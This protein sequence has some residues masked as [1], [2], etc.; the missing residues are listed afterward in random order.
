MR[1]AFSYTRFSSAKSEG[2]DSLARQTREAEAYA[3]RIG[4]RLDKSLNMHDA[5][6]SASKD[7]KG[8][9]LTK[10]AL[11]KFVAAVKAKMIPPNSILIVEAI[12]R[13]TR[14][15]PLEATDLMKIILEAG[16]EIHTIDGDEPKIYTWASVDD[17]D[18]SDLSNQ[19]DVAR[20]FAKKLGRRLAH[21]WSAKKEEMAPGKVLSHWCPAWMRVVDSQL[22]NG[23]RVGGRYELIKDRVLI[24]QEIFRRYADGEGMQTIAAS[25]NARGEPLFTAAEQG[26]AVKKRNNG[27]GWRAVTILALL[28]NVAVLG[29]W[30][31]DPKIDRKAGKV[32]P[33]SIREPV[34]GVYEAIIDQATW[35]RCQAERLR[36]RATGGPKNR[37]LRNL[38]GSLALCEECVGTMGLIGK[39]YHVHGNMV[40]PADAVER[41][42][43]FVCDNARRLRTCSN[44]TSYRAL[45]IE[46][47]VLNG[48]RNLA[49][50]PQRPDDEDTAEIE[51]DI[52][53]ARAELV[54]REMTLD[55]L[56]ELKN[57][58]ASVLSRV[59]KLG[60]EIEA[61]K[62]DI[63]RLEAKRKAL[64]QR[65]Q[66]AEMVNIID[67]LRAE[68]EVAEGDA[69]VTARA[70]LGAYLGSILDFVLFSADGGVL[71]SAGSGILTFFVES[72]APTSVA[73]H[74]GGRMW[75]MPAEGKLGDPVADVPEWVALMRALGGKG[76]AGAV[77]KGLRNYIDASKQPAQARLQK[78]NGTRAKKA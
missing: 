39:G 31:P 35:D 70:A 74:A 73:F 67:K 43:Y 17:G 49:F 14:G 9:H 52:D 53:A 11:G 57:M 42:N 54:G 8:E 4:A 6:F 69:K 59:E 5:A 10:G 68:A 41:G 12:D 63:A 48:V 46:R 71:T 13:L 20:K 64:T 34:P 47:A 77:V 45:N 58:P 36:K 51:R 29:M 37:V 78:T 75:P 66:P 25:L 60:H 62:R 1:T 21:A 22:V 30:Q 27:N 61:L 26:I 15:H 40:R 33:E 28:K 18:W 38:L 55:T 56:F 16:H 7:E 72:G 32:I 23:R 76:R 3:A 65:A 44:R 19:I 24:V 50:V 2:G